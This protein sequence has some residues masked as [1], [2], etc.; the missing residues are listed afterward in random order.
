[1]ATKSNIVKKES[2]N[3][4]YK[5]CIAEGDVLGHL[6]L[7]HTSMYL[8]R[9]MFSSIVSFATVCLT[10]KSGVGNRTGVGKSECLS[11]SKMETGH[12]NFIFFIHFFFL[13][14]ALFFVLRSVFNTD[15]AHRVYVCLCDRCSLVVERGYCQPHVDILNKQV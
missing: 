7:Y 6:F 10:Y 5:Q 1:M 15:K 14:S 2:T 9:H 11:V 8:L 4:V 12:T 13:S 3:Q